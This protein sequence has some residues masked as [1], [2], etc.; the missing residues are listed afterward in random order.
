V[1]TNITPK[2]IVDT[3]DINPIKLHPLGQAM[4]EQMRENLAPKLLP[5]TQEAQPQS[6]E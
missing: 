2:T 4:I 3:Y 5:V 1:R 6:A